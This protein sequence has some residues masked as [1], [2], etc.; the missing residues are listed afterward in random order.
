MAEE[1]VVKFP[2]CGLQNNFLL[3]FSAAFSLQFYET[4]ENLKFYILLLQF[5]F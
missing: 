5:C 3:L 1:E 4:S 2:I